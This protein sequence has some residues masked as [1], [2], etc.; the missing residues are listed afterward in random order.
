MA[1]HHAHGWELHAQLRGGDEP[2]GQPQEEPQEPQVTLS[3]NGHH[4]ALFGA[5]RPT[6]DRD[7]G[8]RADG[9]GKSDAP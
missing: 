3:L 4:H 2:G 1:S 5:R 8:E 9:E 7:H 6:W